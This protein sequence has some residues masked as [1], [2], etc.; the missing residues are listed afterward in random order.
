[1][2]G[3][4]TMSSLQTYPCFE[5]SAK[6][7]TCECIAK[8][9][10]IEYK[11]DV[12]VIWYPVK[13][14]T[15]VVKT[16]SKW[17]LE[18]SIPGVGM[19][20]ES[21]T[22][23]STGQIKS[24]WNS[25]YPTCWDLHGSQ[26]CPNL[27]KCAGLFPGSANVSALSSQCLPDGGYAEDMLCD[28]KVINSISYTEFAGIMTGMLVLS[29]LADRIGRKVGSIITS[30][31]MA[32]G[33]LLMAMALPT[34]GLN[35]M[36]IWF[37]TSF[38]IYGIGV[39][40]EYPISATSA[41][42]RSQK[43]SEPG[44]RGKDIT[45]TFS[46]QGMGAVAGSLVIIAMLGITGQITPDCT[47]PNNNSMGYNE[48]SLGIVWRTT[49]GIGAAMSLLVLVYRYFF[50][51]ES[52]VWNEATE[53]SKRKLA[54][55]V[56]IYDLRKPH[57][58]YG[59]ALRHYWP[60]LMATAGVWFLWDIAFY[61]NKL[62]SGPI[63]GSFVPDGDLLT[64][65]LYIL[66]NNVVGLF[67]Y[68]VAAYLIDQ[69]WVGRLR[70]QVAGLNI[71]ALLLLIS[72]V[73]FDQLAP[74]LLIF[75]YISSSFF[76]SAGPNATTYVV[77]TEVYPVALRATC[78]GMSSFAGKSGALMATIAFQNVDTKTIF[79]VGA[80]VCGIGALLSIVFLPNVAS[81]N[82]IE[83]DRY[84]EM[85]LQGNVLEY[86]GEVMNPKYCSYYERWSGFCERY[87]PQWLETKR[88]VK[89]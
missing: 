20:L 31:L 18:W 8:S 69:K 17:F 19:F 84:L 78:H 6:G 25:A 51:S 46:L 50:L 89:L 71:V 44:S 5:Q 11:A 53:R 79:L 73:F 36:F 21:Y 41:A 40:G 32:L 38:V 9:D 43:H 62:F 55:G 75:F 22:I 27:I 16:W 10:D 81:M 58:A 56:H 68:Y 45:L 26:E 83:N 70:L 63:I 61:S 60:R 39:G 48:K 87:N 14:P 57:V 59:I 3:L 54:E 34:M 76:G 4:N 28:E 67:G 86:Q 52:D 85:I 72:A 37:T 82:M 77:P 2:S 88:E 13:T 1:M 12:S 24:V 66:L 64:T 23:F 30:T 74:G 42:E 49:Y 29:L 7:Q 15:P 65:N 35:A 80:V 33:I 47:T